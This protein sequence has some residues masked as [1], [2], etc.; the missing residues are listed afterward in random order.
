MNADDVVFTFTRFIDPKPFN[1]AFPANFILPNN[2]GLARRLAGIDKLDERTV[3]FRLKEPDVTFAALFA[4]PFAGIQSAEYAA[5]LLKE[6]RAAQI[7]LQPVGTGPYRFKSYA[8][9]MSAPGAP[10][11]TGVASRRLGADLLHQPRAQCACAKAAGRRVP[12]QQPAARC[13][14]LGPRRQ[15]WRGAAEDPGAQHLL[16]E[17]QLEEGAREPARGARALDIAID[18]GAIFKALFPR[19]DAVQATSA[20][21]P[22][23]PGFNKALKNEFNPTR[24]KEL[25][26]KAG[27]PNGF[28]IDLWALPVARPTNPNGQM[29]AQLIQQDWAK[30]GVKATIKTTSGAS[31]SSAPTTASTTS[32]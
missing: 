14:R 28:E 2:L 17:L 11:A 5:H 16:P 32:T 18:R 6:N 26:A 21:P 8:R 27:F 22:G 29:M 24:A 23:I 12:G 3:R 4:Y 20:F 1:Q 30:I 13:G 7:N 31:T 9:T 19:G 10:P 15:A 25:L